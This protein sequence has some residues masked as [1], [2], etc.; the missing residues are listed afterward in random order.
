M[1]M[2]DRPVHLCDPFVQE[3]C[4][5]WWIHTPEVHS[6]W[7]MYPLGHPSMQHMRGTLEYHS[8]LRQKSQLQFFHHILELVLHK[9]PPKPVQHI[10]HFI[11]IHLIPSETL[12]LHVFL[13]H[14]PF[15]LLGQGR[16]APLLDHQ[17]CV[18]IWLLKRSLQ[19]SPQCMIQCRHDL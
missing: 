11:A 12:L 1:G 6:T 9:C 4:D 3:N 7:H 15:V 2:P 14:I 17:T 5:W 8:L 10:K 18:T 13:I 19:L 16:L